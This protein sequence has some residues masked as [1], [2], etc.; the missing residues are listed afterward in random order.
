[1]IH[2]R[3]DYCSFQQ[4]VSWYPFRGITLSLRHLERIPKMKPDKWQSNRKG[5]LEPSKSCNSTL[6]S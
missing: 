1:M 6:K 2:V 5:L 3:K 4:R